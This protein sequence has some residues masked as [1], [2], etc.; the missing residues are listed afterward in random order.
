M[1]TITPASRFHR[2]VKK[3]ERCQIGAEADPLVQPEASVEQ[4]SLLGIY[5]G[6]TKCDD[7]VFTELGFTITDA[8]ARVPIKLKYLDIKAVKYPLPNSD[9]VVLTLQL[10]DGT[11]AF[12]QVVGRQGNFRDVFEV[13]RFFTRVV[14]DQEARAASNS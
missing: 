4:E 13:G 8:C 3:L 2:I 9:S 14:E 10:V 12:V 11:E 7:I 1:N 5:R 6:D